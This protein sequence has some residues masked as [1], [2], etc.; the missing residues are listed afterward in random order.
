M[1]QTRLEKEK[2]KN[3]LYRAHN[4]TIEFLNI[5]LLVVIRL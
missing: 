3:K 2:K 1:C 4:D 5:Q